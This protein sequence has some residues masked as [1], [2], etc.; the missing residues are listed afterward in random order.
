MAGRL[1]TS[2]GLMLDGS[3]A[4]Q[5]FRVVSG[6]EGR[7]EMITR[8]ARVVVTEPGIRPWTGTVIAIKPVK[9]QDPR[10]EVLDEDSNAWSCAAELVEV[11]E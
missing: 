7:W 1:D 10:I 6:H 2:Q 11:I 4:L 3:P 5:G 8:G 9:D